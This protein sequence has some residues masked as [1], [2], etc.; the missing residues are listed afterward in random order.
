[1]DASRF[2]WKSDELKEKHFRPIMSAVLIHRE[3][4]EGTGLGSRGRP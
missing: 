3:F 4:F 2:Y 1:M